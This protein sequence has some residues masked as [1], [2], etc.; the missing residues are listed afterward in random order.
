M[1]LQGLVS[2]DHFQIIRDRP[3][4]DTQ[5]LTDKH[6]CDKRFTINHQ[7]LGLLETFPLKHWFSVIQ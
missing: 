4:H 5:Y 3:Y 7:L 1:D 2:V 6:L